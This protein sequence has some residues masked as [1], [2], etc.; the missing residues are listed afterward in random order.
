MKVNALTDVRWLA[1]NEGRLTPVDFLLRAHKPDLDFD[2]TRPAC[3]VS[4]QFRFLLGLSALA[5][6]HQ[7]P[8]EE[9][10]DPSAVAV[11]ATEGFTQDAVSGVVADVEAGAYLQD[12]TF[13]FMQ[14]PALPPKNAK[15]NSRLVGPGV[16]P[17]KKLSPFMPSDQGEDYWNLLVSFDEKLS[18]EEATLK[19]VTY[20]YFSMAGN[21]VYDGDKTRMGAPGIRFLSKGKAATEFIWRFDG[22][23][24]LK[25]LFA[26][27]PKDW[28]DGTGLPA[29]ADRTGEHSQIAPQEFHPLW[30]ASWSS[31]TAV[32]HWEDL[33]LTGARVCGVPTEWLPFPI[34]S[35][36]RQ[37][38][39]KDWWDTRNEHDPLYLYREDPRTKGLKA[40]RLD[41]GRDGT[42][43]AVEWLADGKVKALKDTTDSHIGTA[44]KDHSATPLFFRHQ[45]EGKA[46][47]PTIRAS[48]IFSPNP[49]LWG[50]DLDVFDQ[51]E[52]ATDA[53]AIRSIHKILTGLFRRRPSADVASEASTAYASAAL[54][55]LGNSRQEASDEFWREVTSTYSDFLASVRAGSPDRDELWAGVRRATLRTFDIVTQPYLGQY[56]SNIYYSRASLS[57]FV[58]RTITRH[59]DNTE[60]GW[61]EKTSNHE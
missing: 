44:K 57:R 46:S 47:S 20:H 48:E 52:V 35:K 2:L 51:I 25:S 55:P 23:S 11:V 59:R 17:V 1:T 43:L 19:L 24:P 4:A 61:K 58:N 36:E 45:I 5:I 50:F 28:I 53:E 39:L 13:P 8:A 54:D 42:D 26:S 16:Q 38:K 21:N 29:W 18:P 34:G 33:Y 10:L 27:L 9:W 7:L 49:D 32:G 40:Q 22:G 30:S 31:N 60:P 3:E 14:R 15:D 41:F 37:A 56:A 6:R 12:D